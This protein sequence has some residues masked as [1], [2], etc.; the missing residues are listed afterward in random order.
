MQGILNGELIDATLYEVVAEEVEVT[1][2]IICCPY[3]A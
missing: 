3:H 2:I 1:L